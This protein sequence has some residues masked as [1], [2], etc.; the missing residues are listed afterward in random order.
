MMV[1]A[2][3]IRMTK[4]LNGP[5]RSGSVALAMSYSCAFAKLVAGSPCGPSS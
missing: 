5:S 1:V 2:D 4:I 3:N